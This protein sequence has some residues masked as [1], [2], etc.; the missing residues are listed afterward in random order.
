[1]FLQRAVFFNLL[2]P[3]ANTDFLFN[4]S[5]PISHHS[6]AELCEDNGRFVCTGSCSIQKLEGANVL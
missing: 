3:L 1:M 2:L 4:I 5:F 6:S